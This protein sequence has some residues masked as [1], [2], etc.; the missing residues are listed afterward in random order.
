LVQ[1]SAASN[2]LGINCKAPAER[3]RKCIIQLGVTSAFC[4]RLRRCN[5]TEPVTDDRS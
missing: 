4:Y 1:G 5:A 2:C 3:I